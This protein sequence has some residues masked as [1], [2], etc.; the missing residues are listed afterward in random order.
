MIANLE[1]IILSAMNSLYN[2][3]GW[4]GVALM[5]VFENATGITPSEVILGLAG[6]MLIANKNVNPAMI[7]LGALFAAIGSVFGASI[8]YWIAR[9][10]GRPVVKKLTRWLRIKDTQV[11]KVEDQFQRWGTGIVLIGRM[12]P[13]VRTLINIPAGLANMTF[14]SFLI[15]TFIGAYI[16]CALLL[17]AGYLL[18]QHWSLISVYL[19]RF[20]P[21]ILTGGSLLIVGYILLTK[22]KRTGNLA[23]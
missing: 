14:L 17:G 8:P 23:G 19:N 1:T 9:L 21:Y 13:G 16:W 6:W 15:N 5:L 22:R 20:I 10:G 3:W 7:L 12:M 11:D 18:G 4:V 2:S